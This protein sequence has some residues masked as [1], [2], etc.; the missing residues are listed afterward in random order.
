MK[1]VFI[2]TGAT[3]G[4]GSAFVDVLC[5]NKNNFVISISRSISENQKELLPANFYF[6]KADLSE[7]SIAEKMIV[8][9]DIIGKEDICFINNASSIEPIVKI[10]DIEEAAMDAVISLTIKSPILMMKYLLK[11]FQ[12]N[13]LTF[14]AIS[15]GA[16]H[17]PISNW[18]LYCSSKAFIE[19][20]FAVAKSEYN[21]YR[22]FTIDPGVM[23]TTMQKK[24]RETDFPELLNFQNL[25][26]E[27]KLK[28]PLDVAKQILTTVL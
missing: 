16:A 23:D 3:R 19:M 5:A 10:E 6:L 24:I 14:V 27:G 20:F 9:K 8:L 4:L 21:Q 7:N 26:A 25:R 11:N 18:S 12:N 2:I 1:K 15:S 17:R 13:K 22:F 28:S